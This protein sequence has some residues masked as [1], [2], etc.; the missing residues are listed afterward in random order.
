MGWFPSG[1]GDAGPRGW[2]R[3]ITACGFAERLLINNIQLDIIIRILKIKH[4]GH[5]LRPLDGFLAG[6][7]AFAGV[8]SRPRPLPA[9]GRPGA[10]LAADQAKIRRD[11]A[12]GCAA[13][14][15]EYGREQD[16]RQLSLD[17]A[18]KSRKK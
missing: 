11:L 14:L 17:L 7:T 8:F 3:R 2:R 9:A 18:P 6:F 4:S 16:A 10:G 12:R 1:S 13:V 5:S 15:A